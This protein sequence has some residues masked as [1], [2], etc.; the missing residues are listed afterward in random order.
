MARIGIVLSVLITAIPLAARGAE[1]P[2]EDPAL[3]IMKKH[4]ARMAAR[5][6]YYEIQLTITDPRG[7]AQEASVGAVSRTGVD[8]QRKTLMVFTAPEAVK[9]A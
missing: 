3:Q 7:K 1:E 5:C 4:A 2:G 6:G 8:G 9:D